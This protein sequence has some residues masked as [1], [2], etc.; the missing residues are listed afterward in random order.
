MLCLMFK[1]LINYCDINSFGGGNGA[2]VASLLGKASMLSSGSEVMGSKPTPLT[3]LIYHRNHLRTHEPLNK[4]RSNAPSDH[5][6]YE[7]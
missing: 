4:H 6:R 7:S 3:K 5:P 1:L 2:V